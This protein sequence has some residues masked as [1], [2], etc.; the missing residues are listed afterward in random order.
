MQPSS[1]LDVTRRADEHLVAV[2]L[3]TRAIIRHPK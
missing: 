1:D 2:I 3:N